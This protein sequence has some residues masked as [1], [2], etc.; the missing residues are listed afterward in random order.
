MYQHAHKNNLASKRNRANHIHTNKYLYAIALF[1]CVSTIESYILVPR[2][3]SNL[4]IY[5]L[6]D[7]V[8]PSM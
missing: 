3:T 4:L 8:T 1:V 7:G 6:E 2:Y 5:I